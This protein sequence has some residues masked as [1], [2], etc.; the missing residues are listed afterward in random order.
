MAT[1]SSWMMKSPFPADKVGTFA[2][3]VF[4]G[5]GDGYQ[6]QVE[7][8]NGVDKNNLM[9]YELLLRDF[10]SEQCLETAMAKLDYLKE[11]GINAIELMPVQEFYGNNSWGYN[12]NF[13]FAPDKY[14]GTSTM[15]KTFVD[16][17][18]RQ[19]VVTAKV[20]MH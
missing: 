12:P 15:Y 19:G 8:F 6:W 9:I 13:Y 18:H 4:H 3:A 1:T 16:E 20:V 2:I 5:N 11:L 10:T 7:D 17:S 14:Y